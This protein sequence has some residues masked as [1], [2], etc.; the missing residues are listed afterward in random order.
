MAAARRVV[1][2]AAKVCALFCTAGAPLYAQ[3]ADLRP[4]ARGIWRDG[5]SAYAMPQPTVEGVLLEMSS[6]ASTI[7]V[8]T[9]TTVH[10][11]GASGTD[12]AEQNAATIVETA[13]AVE[14]SV[15]GPAPGTTYIL[16][17]WAGLWR[18]GPRFSVGQ[19]RLMLLHA[20]GPGG[21]S[22]PVGGLD[23]A[24]PIAPLLAAP[25]SI[26]SASVETGVALVALEARADL[27]WIAAR[28]LRTT[29]AE[30]PAVAEEESQPPLAHVLGL[31]RGFEESRNAAP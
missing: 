15:R 25:H 18:D 9:V 28:R 19:R 16:R 23:G 31:L 7:F 27:R 3:Q 2:W 1:G 13:F 11:A 14:Q 10:F 4:P 6:R 26:D 12:A 17:E 24:I 21:L 5:A 20:P 29:S 30:G 8:G 22:S